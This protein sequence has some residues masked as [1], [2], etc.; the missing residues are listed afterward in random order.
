[1]VQLDRKVPKVKDHEFLSFLHIDSGTEL[2][3]DPPGGDQSRFFEGTYD[4]SHGKSRFVILPDYKLRFG[5]VYGPVTADSDPV[6]VIRVEA[7]IHLNHEAEVRGLPSTPFEPR[8]EEIPGLDVGWSDVGDCRTVEKAL[9]LFFHVLR[10][11]V[12]LVFYN[13]VK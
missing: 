6:R 11:V 13:R 3:C 2:E 9:S 10:I 7:P 4:V 12:L 1:M 5:R 8:Q